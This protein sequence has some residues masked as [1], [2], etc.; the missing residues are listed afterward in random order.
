MPAQSD[1]DANGYNV[2]PWFY[3]VRGFIIFQFVYRDYIVRTVW[4]FAS[5]IGDSTHLEV[6]VGSG[7]FFAWMFRFQRLFRIGAKPT[8]G[9]MFDYEER[10]LNGSRK[11]FGKDPRWTICQA[12]VGDVPFPSNSF[13][14]VNCA[15]AFHCFPDP[16]LA[17]KELARVLAP[18]GSMLI[19]VVLPPTGFGGSV[20]R[21]ILKWGKKNNIVNEAIPRD[22][23]DRVL[24]EAHLTIVRERVSGNQLM[25]WL[26]KEGH[27]PDKDGKERGMTTRRHRRRRR[28]REHHARAHTRAHAHAHSRRHRRSRMFH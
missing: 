12:D 6:A 7:S 11:R 16:G 24:A 19:N 15:N 17:A 1:E 8:S 14:S 22:V 20:A 18:G 3:D 26:T 5:N 23:V 13:T 10:M 25:L 27:S 4:D 2:P 21:K 28:P 9:A